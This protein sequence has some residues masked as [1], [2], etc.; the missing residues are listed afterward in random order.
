MYEDFAEATFELLQQ[1]AAILPN[2]DNGESI[3]AAFNDPEISPQITYYFRVC[4][5]RSTTLARYT[6]H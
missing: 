2:H 4:P 1:T 6:V 5:L 3:L